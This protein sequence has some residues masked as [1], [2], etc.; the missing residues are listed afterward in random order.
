MW[1]LME[2]N[3]RPFGTCP[4]DLKSSYRDKYTYYYY[5]IYHIP[6]QSLSLYEGWAPKEACDL[7]K[8]FYYYYYYYYLIS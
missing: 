1:T 2:M 6:V 7:N 3:Y 4:S 8:L 5:Y